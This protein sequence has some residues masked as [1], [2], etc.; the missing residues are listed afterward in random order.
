MRLHLYIPNSLF[1][2]NQTYHDLQNFKIK[3]KPEEKLKNKN[4]GL[5]NYRNKLLK[6]G[7]IYLTIWLDLKQSV[8][9]KIDFC[10]ENVKKLEN[11]EME[12][13]IW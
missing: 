1:S 7:T 13:K 6:P 5:I 2:Y 4:V 3:K 10:L 8:L 11:W 12:C 9:I